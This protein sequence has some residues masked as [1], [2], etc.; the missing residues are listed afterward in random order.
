MTG[1]GDG[2]T[3]EGTKGTTKQNH[4]PKPNTASFLTSDTE[5]TRFSVLLQSTS[6]AYLVFCSH[7][8][9]I[10]VASE[11][12]RKT[13]R[14]HIAKYTLEGKKIPLMPVGD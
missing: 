10:S 11:E 5:D 14:I 1:V 9:L 4:A 7:P 13:N 8:W 6:L 2:G 3:K 12:G